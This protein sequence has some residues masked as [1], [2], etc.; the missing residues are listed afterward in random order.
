MVRCGHDSV[1]HLCDSGG[2][3]FALPEKTGIQ[4]AASAADIKP[5]DTPTRFRIPVCAGM[6]QL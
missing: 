4:P 3:I 2:I 5:C 1:S 6:T